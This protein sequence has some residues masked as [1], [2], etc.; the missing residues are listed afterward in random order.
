MDV[1]NRAIQFVFDAGVGCD[2]MSCWRSWVLW[3]RFVVLSF[4][5][6]IYSCFARIVF[7][8]EEVEA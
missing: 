3:P 8:V 2:V 5:A 7:V 6:P 4:G 1:V